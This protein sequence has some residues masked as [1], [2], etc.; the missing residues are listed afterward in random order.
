[1]GRRSAHSDEGL[2]PSETEIARRLS[3]DPAAWAAKAIVLERDG[4]PR[5]DPLMGARYWPAVQAYWDRRYGLSRVGASA[6]DGQENLDV[7]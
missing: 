6:L 3:Q 7:L 1:M 4:L 2:F 5:V